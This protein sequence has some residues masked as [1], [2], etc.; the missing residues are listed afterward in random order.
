MAELPKYFYFT[1]KLTKKGTA[2]E[3]EDRSETDVAEVVRCK[4]CKHIGTSD[5]VAY[6][7]FWTLGDDGYCS[8]GERREDE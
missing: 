2:V 8:L 6:E 4:D 3:I 1:V 5:C 7:A